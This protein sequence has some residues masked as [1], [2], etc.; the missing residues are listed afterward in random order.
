MLH[1]GGGDEGFEEVEGAVRV[2]EAGG[3]SARNDEEP[4]R[5]GAGRGEE[6]LQ[7]ETELGMKRLDIWGPLV[8]QA[9]RYSLHQ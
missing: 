5:G 3:V 4:S 6:G 9:D 8:T 1:H 2:E 7:T